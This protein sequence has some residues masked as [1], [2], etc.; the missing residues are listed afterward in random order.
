M[1]EGL[2]IRF[3]LPVLLAL[4]AAAAAGNVALWIGVDSAQKGT[5]LQPGRHVLVVELSNQGE[6]MAEALLGVE[7]S[8]LHKGVVWQTSLAADL[9]GPG[10]SRRFNL[11]F[12]A[13]DPGLYS[14]AAGVCIGSIQ[15]ARAQLD[16]GVSVTTDRCQSWRTRLEVRNKTHLFLAFYYPWYSSPDGPSGIWR[17]WDPGAEYAATHV[18]LIGFYDSCSTEVIS[19]HVRTAQ[20]VGLDGFICSWWGP[21]NY[22][23]DA[24]SKILDVGYGAGFSSTVYLEVVQDAH[25]LYRQLHYVLTRYGSHPVFLRYAERPVIFVYSRVIG[26]LTLGDFAAV[27][28]Q[29]EEQGLPAVYIA[30]SLDARYLDVFD[31]LHTY[32]PLNVMDRYPALVDACAARGKIFAATVAPGYDDTIIRRPGLVV[33]RMNGSFYMGAWEMVM[34]SKPQWVLVTSWNEWHEGSEIEP[35]LEFGDL[36]LNLTA[37]YYGLFESGRLTPRMEERIREISEMFGAAESLIRAAEDKGLDTRFMRRDYS[38]ATDSWKRFDYAVTR[39]YLER[40]LARKDEIPESIL[41][42]ATFL[43]FCGLARGPSQDGLPRRA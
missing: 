24:F 36:Y 23:D 21:G 26:A 35:S 38:I 43:L 19:Y 12:V 5:I 42:A 2:H 31:G 11:S 27:F 37:L 33:D 13:E 39:M 29:L 28:S 40:I 3:I 17:H 10:T 1:P 32:S 16:I 9:P 7:V 8:K 30:D 6:P 41:I 22:I 18:P 34:I 15:V 20:S 25:D 14:V 4:P